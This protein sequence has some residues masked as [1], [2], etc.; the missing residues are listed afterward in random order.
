[1]TY[2]IYLITISMKSAEQSS[3][4]LNSILHPGRQPSIGASGAS[5]SQR[6]QLP[7][8]RK[9]GMTKKKKVALALAS[10]TAI[11]AGTLIGMEAAGVF[12]S[13]SDTS[14]KPVS[15][16]PLT[17]AEATFPVPG[18]QIGK[19]PTSTPTE[20]PL[21]ERLPFTIHSEVSTGNMFVGT[22]EDVHSAVPCEV[23]PGTT[24][25]CV[26]LEGLYLDKTLDPNGEKQKSFD[27][28]VKWMAWKDRNPDTTMTKEEFV[29]A[30]SDPNANLTVS[31]RGFEGASSLPKEL[32]VDLKKPIHYIQTSFTTRSGLYK[33]GDTS[34]GSLILYKGELYM[35]MANFNQAG[36]SPE[37]QKPNL[38]LYPANFGVTNSMA[39]IASVFI[40][41]KSQSA[42]NILY[43]RR[44][45]MD[46]NTAELKKDLWTNMDHPD[47]IVKASPVE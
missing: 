47:G 37:F 41:S 46:S 20:I 43:E 11:G 34:D 33:F 24:V 9:E 27:E 30:L 6:E 16:A 28:K 39:N 23:K 7:K 2:S 21:T 14:T 42:K 18:F 26:G 8:K 19:D 36:L 5:S 45:Q 38:N 22:S 4:T 3:N 17:T 1:M 29:R 15:T 35:A 40:D 44:A 13:S 25:T 32:S 10:S 12:D 31:F